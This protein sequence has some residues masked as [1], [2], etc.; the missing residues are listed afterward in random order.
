MRDV[1]WPHADRDGA[2]FLSI[3]QVDAL[4]QASRQAIARAQALRL[5]SERARQRAAQLRAQSKDP[6]MDGSSSGWFGVAPRIKPLTRH[7]SPVPLI[8]MSGRHQLRGTAL[9]CR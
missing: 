8:G 3:E 2:P 7:W 9:I 1:A 6:G 5:R 4:S